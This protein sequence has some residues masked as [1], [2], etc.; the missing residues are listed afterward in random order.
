M[1]SVFNSSGQ[2]ASEK[3]KSALDETTDKSKNQEGIK[4]TK[5]DKMYKSERVPI[6]SMSQGSETPQQDNYEDDYELLSE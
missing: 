3:V 4:Q 1:N 2:T 6:I 5:F